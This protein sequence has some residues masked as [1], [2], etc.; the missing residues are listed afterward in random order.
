M[1]LADCGHWSVALVTGNG[2]DAIEARGCNSYGYNGWSYIL[3]NLWMNELDGWTG[4]LNRLTDKHSVRSD[5]S[6]NGKSDPKG[7]SE[8]V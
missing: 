7:G 5:P 2:D 1:L 3:S 8:F 6:S 4:N